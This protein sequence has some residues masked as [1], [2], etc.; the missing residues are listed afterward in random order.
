MNWSL[1]QRLWA[2]A[3]VVIAGIAFTGYAVFKSNQKLLQSAEW[4]QHTEKV[5]YESENVLSL[6]KDIQA[7]ARGYALTADSEFLSPLYNAR[8]KV[9]LSLTKLKNL[10][11]DNAS[12]QKRIDSLY[13]YVHKRIEFTDLTITMRNNEGI[14][15]VLQLTATKQGKRYTDRVRQLT[16]DI[17][18]EENVLL[19]Q[20]ETENKESIQLFNRL[21]AAMFLLMAVF[22][23]L[24]FAAVATYLVN[25]QK[26]STQMAAGT[27]ALQLKMEE[28]QGFRTMF[29]SAPGLFLILLPDLSIDAV[30]DAYLKA[31]MTQRKQIVGRHLFDV[32]PDNPDDPDADGVNKL[33]ASLK[34]V[35][36]TKRPHAMAIQKYDIRRPSG[37]FEERYWS[38]LNK[39]VLNDE[40]VVMFIIHSVQDVTEQLRH[41]REMLQA[42]NEIKELYDKAPCGYFSVDATISISNINET[43]LNWLGYTAEEVVGKMK[44][45]DLLSAE[46]REKHLS[47]F[48]EVFAE[49]V[50][51]GYVNDL[52][53]EFQRKNGSTFPALVNSIAILDDKGSF[54]KSRSTVFDNTER[55]K[56]E[57]QLKAVNKELESFSYSVSHDLRAP[58]RAVNGYARMLVEDYE[59]NMDSEGRRMLHTIM[60]SAKKMSQLIDDLLQFS[61]LS[62][63]ELE[64][65]TIYTQGMVSGICEEIRNAQPHRKVNFIV[66]NLPDVKADSMIK[67][68]WVNLINNAVKYSGNRE[69][70]VIEIKA[71]QKPHEVVFTVT[72]NGAGFDMRYANKLFGVFQRLHTEDEFEG[73]GVGLAIVQRIVNKHDGKVWAFGEVGKGATFCFSI[74]VNNP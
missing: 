8:G 55:K 38:P 23:I 39:P 40:G 12:Q 49:Y 57:E 53:Y 72:D 74:P 27:K 51:S 21:T 1:N 14:Q 4:V 5:I 58:L 48:E 42:A 56:A 67:Q 44:Y 50:K 13:Y 45:E 52:E 3:L 31:T 11:K 37:V 15:P 26:H 64:K 36:Q 28:L 60:H 61:R 20:R 30:S 54:V 10:T 22:S 16:A 71:E 62:R 43:L 18:Q 7:A 41:E 32:F 9:F 69:E 24:L 6:V 33:N 47:T 25:Q 35:L 68:V 70:S 66:S 73:T 29:E 59:S 17:Q 34:I 65:I 2:L 19:Q 46:S 63:R